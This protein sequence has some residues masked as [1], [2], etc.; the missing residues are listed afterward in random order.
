MSAARVVAE[1]MTDRSVGPEAVGEPGCSG[2]GSPAVSQDSG[3]AVTGADVCSA[4]RPP[5]RAVWNSTRG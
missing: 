5:T 4:P 3:C 1:T 2:T